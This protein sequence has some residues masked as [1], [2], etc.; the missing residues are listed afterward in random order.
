MITKRYFDTYQGVNTYLYTLY[1]EN[2][3]VD[4]L[5]FGASVYAVRLQTK[6]GVK[7]VALHFPT[8][9]GYIQS[10]AY[11]GATVGRVANRIGGASFSLNG[12]TYALS[13]NEGRNQLHGGKVGFS[14]RF[15][16]AEIDGNV[17]K[18][19]LESE[20]GD[21]GYP[22]N[23]T[24]TVEYE[25]VHGALEIRFSA[26][27]DG[28][29]AWAPTNHTYFNLN[30]EGGDDI[31]ATKLLVNAEYYTILDSEHIPT[32]EVAPVK[33]SPF[34]FTEYKEIG[35]EID[36]DDEQLRF[37]KGYDCNFI[38]KGELAAVAKSEQSGIQLSVYTDMP[39]LQFYSGNY[40]EG[41]GKTRAYHPRYAFCLE[42]QYVP[43][44]VNL[45]R[46]QAPLLKKG[47]K[48]TQ[49]IRYAFKVN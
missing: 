33:G 21:Q 15:W 45:P 16:N 43:N 28:D 9:E 14:Y 42:P 40:L 5:D 32:G 4:V 3:E 47:E 17:L 18:M 34:D 11:C 37:S 41:M 44:A 23:V 35:K 2:I 7:D 48:R 38:L 25:L 12:K 31:L 24:M 30:G 26:I 20:D 39:G 49:Y 6:K 1:G 29:T 27:S 8:I 46:F 13:A 22:H 36:A 10:G 19:T